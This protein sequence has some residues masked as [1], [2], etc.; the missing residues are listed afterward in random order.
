VGVEEGRWDKEDT[1]RAEDYIFLYGKGNKN[2]KLGTGIFVHHRILSA[3][4][5]AKFFSDR[6]SYL[7]LRGR[8][9]DIIILNV[10]APS[11]EK[12][13]DSKGAFLW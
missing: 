12:S 13:D 11:V 5:R 1:V 2:H 6:M 7:V 8:W 4:K 3:V 9:C 10:D